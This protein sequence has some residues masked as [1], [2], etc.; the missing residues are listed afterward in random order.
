M[1]DCQIKILVYSTLTQLIDQL[2]NQSITSVKQSSTS[3]AIDQP[4]NQLTVRIC[5][6]SINHKKFNQCRRQTKRTIRMAEKN[7]EAIKM[8]NGDLRA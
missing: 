1:S 6:R 7:K 3:Q 4:I 8:I 5:N 2:I